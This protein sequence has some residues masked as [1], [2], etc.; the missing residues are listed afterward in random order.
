MASTRDNLRVDVGSWE[1]IH[2]RN[3]SPPPESG[4][5][6][7]Q[8]YEPLVRDLAPTARLHS[9]ERGMGMREDGVVCVTH[10]SVLART[11]VGPQTVRGRSAM[12][13]ILGRCNPG[14]HTKAG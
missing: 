6:F 10:P 7:N 3:L 2:F 13:A 5:R 14:A 4:S 12:L 11:V 1:T 9:H 8:V